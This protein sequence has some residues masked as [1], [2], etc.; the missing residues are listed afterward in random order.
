MESAVST[1]MGDRLLDFMGDPANATR[2]SFGVVF[3]YEVSDMHLP[4]HFRILELHLKVSQ[5]PHL[6]CAS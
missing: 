6:R 5:K 3:G 1:W 4:Y 2:G